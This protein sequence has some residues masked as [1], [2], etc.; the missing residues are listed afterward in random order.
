MVSLFKKYIFDCFLLTYGNKWTS[1]VYVKFSQFIKFVVIN[2]AMLLWIPLVLFNFPSVFNHSCA[3]FLI[4]T[5][6]SSSIA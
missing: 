1:K 3:P 5:L 4:L 6:L 2:N